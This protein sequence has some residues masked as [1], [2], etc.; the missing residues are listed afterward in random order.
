MN[1]LES[2]RLSSPISK[3]MVGSSA[4]KPVGAGP[5]VRVDGTPYAIA[6]TMDYII[7]IIVF[8]TP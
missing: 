1:S 3:I 6:G 2:K 4:S 5:W 8:R 7:A